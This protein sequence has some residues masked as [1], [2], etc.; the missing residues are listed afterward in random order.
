M[1]GTPMNQALGLTIQMMSTANIINQ[2]HQ[3]IFSRSDHASQ[4]KKRIAP[5]GI[6]R[7]SPKGKL[8]GSRCHNNS[9]TT[10]YVT[11]NAA[12]IP[13][14]VRK[15]RRDQK[16]TKHQLPDAP[17]TSTPHR[18]GAA[19]CCQDEANEHEFTCREIGNTKT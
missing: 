15:G 11:K 10:A 13:N 18:T 7:T 14:R 12:M 16:R 3:G 5:K 1:I 17:H 8:P 2:C 9:H 4:I 6:S 19:G